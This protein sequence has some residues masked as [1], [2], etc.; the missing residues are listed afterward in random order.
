MIDLEEEPEENLHPKFNKIL[1]SN[2]ILK[3]Q[4]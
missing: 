3:K 4:N 2:K 1:F